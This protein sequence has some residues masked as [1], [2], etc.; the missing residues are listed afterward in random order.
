MPSEFCI[1]NRFFS[2]D[3][4]NTTKSPAAIRVSFFAV[5]CTRMCLVSVVSG[6]VLYIDDAEKGL[7]YALS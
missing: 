7:K 6:T 5:P 2:C 1:R 4:W 3:S